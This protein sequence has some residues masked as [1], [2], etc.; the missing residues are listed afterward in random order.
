MRG[1]SGRGMA[2][3][4]RPF[5]RIASDCGQGGRRLGFRA[6]VGRVPCRSASTHPIMGSMC[7][8]TPSRC[9]L[10]HRRMSLRTRISAWAYKSL[11]GR[12]LESPQREAVRRALGDS[13][14]RGVWRSRHRSDILYKPT[15]AGNQSSA[16]GC[17]RWLGGVNPCWLPCKS[18]GKWPSKM[19]GFGT[20]ERCDRGAARPFTPTKGP[21]H[22]FRPGGKNGG[23]S[24]TVKFVSLLW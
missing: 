9:E 11:A 19:S 13:T 2:S 21:G 7:T 20:Y 4:C 23:K 6:G 5:V 8:E 10:R 18:A 17:S 16:C 24:V 12:P 14:R 15:P 3:I 1:R 22:P